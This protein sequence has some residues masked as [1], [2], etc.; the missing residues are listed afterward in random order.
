MKGYTTRSTSSGPTPVRF[1]SSARARFGN[2]ACSL[3]RESRSSATALHEPSAYRHAVASLSSGEM[4]RIGP[5]AGDRAP[6]RDPFPIDDDLRAPN[7][8]LTPLQTLSEL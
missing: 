2:P 8:A 5:R 4:P 1:H 7:T 6:R 3:I